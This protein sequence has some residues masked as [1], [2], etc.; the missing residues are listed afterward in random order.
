MIK[1][2]KKRSQAAF[3]LMELLVVI[4]II[5]LL[6]AIA[7]PA[8]VGSRERAQRLECQVNLRNLTTA[9]LIYSSGNDERLCSADNRW[10]EY[11]PSCWVVDG[12]LFWGNWVGGTVQAVKDGS[13]WPYTDKKIQIYK[14][15]SDRSPL[16][17]SYAISRAM[18]GSS[19]ACDDDH[20]KPYKLYTRI[21]QPSERLVFIDAFSRFPWIDGSFCPVEDVLASPLEWSTKKSL[22]IT[23]RH[24]GG[25][26]ISFA[27]N[28]CDYLKW[29]DSRTVGLAN[30]ELDNDQ[31][32]E[33]NPDLARIVNLIKGQGK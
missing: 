22:N 8:L 9:W 1:T 31:A 6:M 15:S 11:D 13:L 28:S 4:S 32:S 5:S 24:N 29:K 21:R 10:K 30:F 12:P 16:L 20:I 7:I 19:C 33:N 3:T 2:H 18:N 27:D 26:N 14:C 25:T 17:R 23:A